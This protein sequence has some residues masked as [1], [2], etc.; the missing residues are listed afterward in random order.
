MTQ[1]L[2]KKV[3]LSLSALLLA[4]IAYSQEASISLGP[5]KIGENQAWT[6]TITV[7]NERL[8]KYDDFPDIEGFRKRGTS[9]SSNTQ[10][11]N[12]Q[13]SS[14]QSITMTYIP[15]RQ[16]TFKVRGFSMQINGKQASS[17]G[18]TVKVGPPVQRQ[19]RRDPF[20]S[21]F[22]R[23]PFDPNR[24]GGTEFVDV[25][26]DAFLALTTNKK[27][28][29]VGE[30]FTT[31]LSF[32]VAE[33]NRAPLQFYELGKQL[34]DVLKKVRPENCWEENFNIENINGEPV[35]ISGKRYTQYK[36]YQGV[37]YPLND[38]EITFPSVGL[39]MIKYKV[40]KNPSFFGQNRQE[41]FKTFYSR[42][43]K[44][45]VNELPPHPLRDQV[46]VGDYLLDE[47]A[48]SQ[49]LETG[50]SFS[51][52]FNVYGE[53]NISG[54]SNPDIDGKDNFDFYDPNVSENINRRNGRVTGSKS[55]SYFG[56]PKEPGEY[57]L[58]DYFNWIFFNPKSERYDTLS[59]KLIVTV[60]GESKKNESIQSNDLGSFYDRIAFEDNT[61]SGSA[62]FEWAK[63]IA[64]L[65]IIG[66]LVTSAYIFI[67]K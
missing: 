39:E 54:V 58:S 65:F 12:G 9:S 14:S 11:I 56:I 50:Q 19:Q 62:R 29:Y 45:I 16:G 36:V 2:L 27:E 49:E 67:K 5:S 8:K 26:D 13:I 25:K 20:R 46:A 21:F 40:A 64:N 42:E 7:K 55:F 41:D 18:T 51:Y 44:V 10:I 61:L 37:F 66:M 22:D 1:G 31:T 48:S 24:G 28:V 60:T 38:E 34:S 3:F 30:G 6:I 59:S 43:K 52:E 35:N 63:I 23:D 4:V 32:Y 57:K 17:D 15:T 47:R 53:G 33:D